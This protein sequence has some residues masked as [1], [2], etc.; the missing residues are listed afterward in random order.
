MS[1]GK[2]SRLVY[3][4]TRRSGWK[5]V[6]PSIP[7]QTAYKE[8]RWAGDEIVATNASTASLGQRMLSTHL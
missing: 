2:S 6:G 8:P 5:E 4:I 3:Y 1:S 7:G